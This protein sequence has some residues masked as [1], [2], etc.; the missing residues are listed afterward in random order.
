ML[1]ENVQLRYV[2]EAL[3][4]YD[5]EHLRHPSS[6]REKEMKQALGEMIGELTAHVHALVEPPLPI[7][8][9]PVADADEEAAVVAEAA[10]EPEPDRPTRSHKRKS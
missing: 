2:L 8:P 6:D 10:D 9:E 5:N 7:E 4:S 1:P 3:E